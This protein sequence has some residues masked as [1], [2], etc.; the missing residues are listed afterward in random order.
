MLYSIG[1]N[2]LLSGDRDAF[3]R[4]LPQSLMALDWC[5]SE[6]D[7]G[8]Q[9]SEVPGV[10]VAPLNDLTHESRDW[11]FPNAYFVSGMEVFGQALLGYGHPRADQILTVA[12]QMRADVTRAFARASVK[13]P[14]VQLADGGWINYVPSDALTPRRMLEEWYPTDVDCGPLHLSRLAA[15]DPQHWMTTAM[16][17]DHEDNLF[18]G[19]K[20]MA[21]EPFYNQQATTYLYRDEPE[22]AIRAFYSMLTCAFSHRQLTPL[23]HQ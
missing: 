6:I 2:F 5:L 19:Q 21:N 11:G 1:Q 18:L 3:E 22:A 20:G 8:T 4:L 13:S 9:H 23:E 7:K 15:I 10:V 17:H 14:V 16:L 12:R